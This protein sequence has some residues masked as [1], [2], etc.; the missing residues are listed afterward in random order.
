MHEVRERAL[1]V[2]LD[3]RQPLAIPGLE[4]RIAGDVDLVEL[5]RLLGPHRLQHPPR[6]SAQVALRRV[7]ERDADYGYRPRVS[8]ASATRWTA[9]PYAAS[10]IVVDLAS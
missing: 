7:V 8:V 1:A 4:V 10:R 6:G 9:R 2:D 3:D 5:E